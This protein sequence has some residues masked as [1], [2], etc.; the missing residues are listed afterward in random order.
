M[1]INRHSLE[2]VQSVPVQGGAV[3]VRVYKPHADK[4]CMRTPLLVT[5]GGP[6]GSSIGLYDAL[7]QVADQRPVIFYDQLGSCSSPA[8]LAPEQMT[9]ER[10]ASEPLQILEQL[11]IENACLLGHSWGGSV[12]TQ[13]CLDHPHRVSALVLSSP[14]LS[15]RRWIE[16]CNQLIQNIKSELGDH[17]EVEA[18]FDRR[19]FSRSKKAAQM[20][21]RE[22]CRANKSLYERMWGSSEFIHSGVLADL[23]FFHRLSEITVPTM[24][25][26]GDHDTAT[27]STLQQARDRIGTNAKLK[28][29]VD[30]G[31]K[32]YVDCNHQFVEVVNNFFNTLSSPERSQVSP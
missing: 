3:E 27:P 13:F 5:H 12:M 24:L 8:E 16:D 6:G 4:A 17:V 2:Q 21:K 14:L 19:H 11:G 20:L 22:S 32:T 18:E 25:I 26:C 15:T 10:F 28:V 30:S 23:D 7:H 1:A 9:L 31:H 29:L